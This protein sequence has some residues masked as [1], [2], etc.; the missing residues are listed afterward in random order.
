M[1]PDSKIKLLAVCV[2]SHERP[3]F[4][5]LQMQSLLPLTDHRDLVTTYI[6]D[7]SVI[8]SRVVAELSQRY[9]VCLLSTPGSSQAENF[10][11]LLEI[12]PHSYYMLLHDDDI[13]ILYDVFSFLSELRRSQSSLSLFY[14]PSITIKDDLLKVF[15][16]HT[17][18]IR[19]PP[20]GNS[21][22][23][24]V[25]PAFSSW[26][27]PHTPELFD[28]FQNHFIARPL[29]K[30]SDVLFIDRLIQ[31]LSSRDDFKI[32]K[33]RYALNVLRW[34]PG[35]DSWSPDYGLRFRLISSLT[36]KNYISKLVVCLFDCVVNRILQLICYVRSLVSR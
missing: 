4:L 23:P 34:H 28:S 7:N 19:K 20:L 10:R 31:S 25:V 9:R 15:A 2:I 12:E 24:W 13:T 16:S 21:I 26:I 8:S 32:L 36:Y 14:V 27:Y 18:L 35:Q 33:N 11:K 17:R 6:F 5:Q 29:G 22:V 1:N 3:E 30:F